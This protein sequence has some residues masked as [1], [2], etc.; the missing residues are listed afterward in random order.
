MLQGVQ[1]KFYSIKEKENTI[2]HPQTKVFQLDY[3]WE[4]TV[5]SK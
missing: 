4:I 1:T 2:S 3:E 5:Y